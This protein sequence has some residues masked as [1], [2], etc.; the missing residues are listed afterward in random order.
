MIEEMNNLSENEFFD[1]YF[2]LELFKRTSL[3]P[4]KS[5][6]GNDFIT[7]D[8]RNCTEEFLSKAE[9]LFSSKHRI[10]IHVKGSEYYLEV[11]H[12]D[13]FFNAYKKLIYDE[14]RVKKPL[15]IATPTR[16]N[17]TADKR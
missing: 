9:S 2:L 16:R 6:E 10:K 15:E 3:L 17:A 11:L 5:D 12:G 8:I 1:N 14:P 13:S 4:F 7:V